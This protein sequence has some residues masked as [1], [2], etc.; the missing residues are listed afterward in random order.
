MSTTFSEIN[1]MKDIP[2]LPEAFESYIKKGA[3]IINEFKDAF[4]H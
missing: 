1:L 3:L 2:D 4:F